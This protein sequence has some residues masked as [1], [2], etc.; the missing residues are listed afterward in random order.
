MNWSTSQKRHGYTKR[1][2]LEM[3]LKYLTKT[4]VELNPNILRIKKQ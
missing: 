4:E 3:E 2:N 1:S